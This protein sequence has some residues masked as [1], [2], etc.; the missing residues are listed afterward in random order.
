MIKDAIEISSKPLMSKAA[1]AK[2]LKISRPTLYRRM[3]DNDFT[4]KMLDKLK[5]AG[6]IE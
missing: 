2:L 3:K 4:K 5:K 6:V 1:I